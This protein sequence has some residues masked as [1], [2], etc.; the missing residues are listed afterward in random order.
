MHV[1]GE[2][3]ERGVDR[4]R[5]VEVLR[6]REDRVVL[7]GAVGDAGDRER[8]HEGPAAAVAHR[9]LELARGLSGIAQREMRDGYQPA[10]GVAAEIGDPAIV[11]A[12]V[13]AGQLG[14]HQLGLPKQ[15]DG[16]VEDRFGHALALEQLHALGHVHGAERGAAQVGLLRSRANPPSLFRTDLTAHGSLAQPPRLVHPLAHAAQGAELAGAGQGGALAVDLQ[17]LVT[18]VADPDADRATAVAGLEILLP[19]V[20]RLEDVPVAVDDHG[21]SR[22]RRGGPG[23]G[24]RSPVHPRRARVSSWACSAGLGVIGGSPCGPGVSSVGPRI[25]SKRRRVK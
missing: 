3:L 8:A 18:V 11:R 9:A 21:A 1:P 17:I 19:Q 20:G 15:P 14:V 25:C 12:A 16:R 13:G 23:S 24:R 5:H 4:E 10:P 22:I 2:R 6:G 7:G